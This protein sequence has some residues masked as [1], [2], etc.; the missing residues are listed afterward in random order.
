[1]RTVEV[2]RLEVG[3]RARP[4]QLFFVHEFRDAGVAASSV[5]HLAFA[6]SSAAH[7]ANVELT[8]WLGVKFS[9]RTDEMAYRI[10]NLP[11]VL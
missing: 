3:E 1:L 7:E 10:G 9:S 5:S 8:S 2:C 4:F 6:L 11:G